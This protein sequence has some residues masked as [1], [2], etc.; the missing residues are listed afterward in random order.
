[1]EINLD[2]KKMVLNNGEEITLSITHSAMKKMV[3][4]LVANGYLTTEELIILAIG[5]I[6]LSDK[7]HLD[8]VLPELV[9]KKLNETFESVKN[10]ETHV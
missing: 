2:F 10:G 7:K 9:L 5:Q 3:M 4:G 8:L 6:K 1:M